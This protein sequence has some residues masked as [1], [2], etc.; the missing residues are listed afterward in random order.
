ME[1][2]AVVELVAL[3][4]AGV[5]LLGAFG[6]ADEVGYGFGCVFLEE[7]DDDGAFGGLECG[8]G[9]GF[10]WHYVSSCWLLVRGKC[11]PQGLKP[12]LFAD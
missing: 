4:G 5:P 11:I 10:G 12:L 1:D 3:L 2:G 8:V 9:S 6:E 7:F